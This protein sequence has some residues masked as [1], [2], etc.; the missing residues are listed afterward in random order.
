MLYSDIDKQGFSSDLF[1]NSAL[2][3]MYG[4]C[5]SVRVAEDTF[6]ASPEKN[7]VLWNAILSLYVRQGLEEKV[8]WSYKNMRQQ[9]M[10]LDEVVI[11]RTL[12]G[13]GIIGSLDMCRQLHFDV[14][15]AG[16][17]LFFKL[18]VAAQAWLMP[19]IH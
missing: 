4:K 14:V 10:I 16:Y 13:S 17:Q 3:S 15:C 19:K 9:F 2:I 7:S 5:R 8:I 12:Q 6:N 11:I 18:T 1:V